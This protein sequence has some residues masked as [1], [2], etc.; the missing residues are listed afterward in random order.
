MYRLGSQDG[1]QIIFSGD[2]FLSSTTIQVDRQLE[3]RWTLAAAK[4]G[5]KKA[6]V[7]VSK[8]YCQRGN[9]E[10]AFEWS[11]KVAE[12]GDQHAQ[13]DLGVLYENGRGC[14]INFFKAMHW[15]Q[16]SAAQGLQGSIDVVERMEVQLIMSKAQ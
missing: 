5:N 12:T 10:S 6:M 1:P 13:F 3:F 11:V 16:K 8:L 15:Y 7:R 14:E 9:F 2:T 4:Q